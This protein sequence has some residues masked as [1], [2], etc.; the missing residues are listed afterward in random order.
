MAGRYH[1]RFAVVRG[2]CRTA[3]TATSRAS[4]SIQT[5]MSIEGTPALEVVTE[6]DNTDIDRARIVINQP[7]LFEVGSGLQLHSL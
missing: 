2:R 7:R 4:R 1:N 5:G 6:L 3:P